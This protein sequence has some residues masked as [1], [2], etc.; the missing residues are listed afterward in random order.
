MKIF[1][2][3]LD[4][5]SIF[6]PRGTVT[7]DIPRGYVC[8]K[9]GMQQGNICVWAEVDPDQKNEC[10][11]FFIVGSGLDTPAVKCRHLD[12]VF[13]GVYVLHIYMKVK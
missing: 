9:V 5:F 13:V 10:V 4:H 1:K 6:L 7:V 12:T 11:T 2:Y 3:T 8:L